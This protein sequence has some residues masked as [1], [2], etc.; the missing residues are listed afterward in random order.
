MKDPRIWFDA[1]SSVTVHSTA[2]KRRGGGG[3]G[4]ASAGSVTPS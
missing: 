1:Q 3:A 4:A 2:W